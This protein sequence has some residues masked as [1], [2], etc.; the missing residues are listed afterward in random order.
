VLGSTVHR[1]GMV[2]ALRSLK[3][4]STVGLVITAS[5]NPVCDNGVKIAD[6]DGSM[7]D[8]SWEPF[9]NALA[10]APDPNSL[11]QVASYLVSFY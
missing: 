2:A 9:A 3:T 8:Q 10:N 7:M 1:A 5:H 4:G 11:A 6:P